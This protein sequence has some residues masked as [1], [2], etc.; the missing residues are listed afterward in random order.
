MKIKCPFCEYWF[1]DKCEM[2]MHFYPKQKFDISYALADKIFNI[3]EKIESIGN[4]IPQLH[5]N[6]TQEIAF[7]RTM[8]ALQ[9]LKSLLDNE[10]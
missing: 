7:H 4:E 10:K 2:A 8:G 9:E 3:H 5:N 6:K 1:D